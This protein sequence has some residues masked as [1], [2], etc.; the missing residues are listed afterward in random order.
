M[1][2]K[3]FVLTVLKKTFS[4][5]AVWFARKIL[6]NK[7]FFFPRAKEC[8]VNTDFGSISLSSLLTPPPLHLKSFSDAFKS[9]VVRK[10]ST[11]TFFQ[12]EKLSST[13][14]F[15]KPKFFFDR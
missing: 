11:N 15:L 1:C 3:L 12:N 13:K 10:V 9:L 14:T 7:N 5:Q 8:G 4:I 2:Q 6:S